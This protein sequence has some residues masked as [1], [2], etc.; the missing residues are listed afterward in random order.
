LVD[1]VAHEYFLQS[2]EAERSQVVRYSEREKG[3]KRINKIF[4]FIRCS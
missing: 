3:M 1:E 2:D 4:I